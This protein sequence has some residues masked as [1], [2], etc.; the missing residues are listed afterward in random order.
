MLFVYLVIKKILYRK[1]AIFAFLLSF[2]FLP[3]ARAVQ[4]ERIVGD[5]S[6][7]VIITDEEPLCWFSPSHYN[8]SGTVTLSNIQYDSFDRVIEYHATA[9]SNAYVIETHIYDANYHHWDVTGFKETR[10]Y[11]ASG[12]TYEIEVSGASYDSH[13]DVL[14][15]YN[16]VVNLDDSPILPSKVI[17][18]S[19]SNGAID[20]AATINLSWYRGS[21][22]ASYDIYLGKDPNL[23]DSTFQGNQVATTFFSGILEYD[24]T[25]YW[26][27]DA[28]NFHGTTIGDIWTFSTITSAAEKIIY[29]DVNAVGSNNG[30]SW[31]NAYNCLQDALAEADST[32]KRIDILVA[33]GIYTPDQG[34]RINLGDYNAVFQLINKVSIEGGYAGSG[35]IDPSAR[36]IVAHQTILSGDIYDYT[37]YNVVSG[38]GTNGTAVLDGFIITNGAA[39]SSYSIH[40]RGGGMYNEEGNPTLIDCTFIGN[41]AKEGGGMHN[42]DSSNP[43]LINCMF[44]GNSASDDGGGI[45][46]D[47]HSNPVLIKCWF[48]GNSA[49]DDGGGVYNDH[50]SPTLTN[51]IFSGNLASDN[52]GG[53]HNEWASNPILTNCTLSGNEAGNE[54]SGICNYIISGSIISNCILWDNDKEIWNFGDSIITITYSNIFGGLQG[55][56]NINADPLFVDTANGDYHLK[57][58]A[59]RW[60]P[61]IK[62]WIIDSVT[63]PCIDAGDPNSLVGDEPLP[64]GG[65]INMGAYGGTIEASK[66]TAN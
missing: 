47:D 34:S 60:D 45:Y 48:S 51:C 2:S 22:A 66:S 13:G 6:P 5:E 32:N 63:S 10:F 37:S 64:N 30:S 25:Y 23:D 17:D 50:S 3:T 9:V 56:G 46:N 11:P 26:R 41:F 14:D 43:V 58:Q 20:L 62:T 52:G 15:G 44:I 21:S 57:S 24:T 4:W 36:D 54:G 55:V 35:E 8:A 61:N 12:N 28:K 33:Q 7:G 27:V 49:S 53:L 29:V 38:S 40:S 59:G 1:S 39:T 16:V 19:P 42:R 31:A 65:I 18:P